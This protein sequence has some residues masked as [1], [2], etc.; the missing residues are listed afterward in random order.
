M[1]RT[2]ALDALEVAR[3]KQG[4]TYE[5]LAERVGQGKMW[6]ITAM[7]GQHYVPPEITKSLIKTGCTGNRCCLSFR[8]FTVAMSTSDL[9]VTES[10][11]LWAFD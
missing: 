1:T 6:V 11:Y 7:M 10:R 3:R 2:E 9:P 8:V 5:Q 4:L